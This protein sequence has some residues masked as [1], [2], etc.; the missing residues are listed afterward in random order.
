MVRRSRL[1][2][3]LQ[4]SAERESKQETAVLKLLTGLLEAVILFHW[5]RYVIWQIIK[6]HSWSLFMSISWAANDKYR[7]LWE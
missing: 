7:N 4:R 6:R 3:Q 1:L 2:L 5:V